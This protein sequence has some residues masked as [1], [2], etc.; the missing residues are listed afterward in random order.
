[1]KMEIPRKDIGGAANSLLEGIAGK[2]NDKGVGVKLADIIKF[3]V[4][5]G[6]TFKKPVIKN[7]MKE[8]KDNAVNDLKDK[9]KEEFDKKKEELLKQF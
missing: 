5:I 6:G 4:R 1:M 8:V 9:A 3:D 2:A 7:G